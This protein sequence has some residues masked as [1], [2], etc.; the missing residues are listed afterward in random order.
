MQSHR[1]DAWELVKQQLLVGTI[2]TGKIYYRAPY[3][4]FFD[5]G[6]GFPV[7]IEV[8]EFGKPE[9]GM[10]F[11]EDYPALG[12]LI[13]G[14]IAGFRDEMRQIVVVK[15]GNLLFYQQL[16]RTMGLDETL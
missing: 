13:S 15:I 8:P 16:S 3:G 14:E 12:S 4:V 5:A 6:V 9:G 7:L 10:V 11:S 1:A 2:L